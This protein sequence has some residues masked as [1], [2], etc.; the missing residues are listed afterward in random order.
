MTKNATEIIG[1]ITLETLSR[2]RVYIDMWDEKGH[3]EVD[4]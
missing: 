3:Y 4:I 2:N 1:P